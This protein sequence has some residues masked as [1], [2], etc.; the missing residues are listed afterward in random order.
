MLEERDTLRYRVEV[1]PN[2]IENELVHIFFGSQDTAPAPDPREVDSWRWMSVDALRR[3]VAEKWAPLHGVVQ[4][5]SRQN[6]R[7][8]TSGLTDSG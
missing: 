3:D 8:P 6:F 4:D 2:L 7:T 5:L 1:P